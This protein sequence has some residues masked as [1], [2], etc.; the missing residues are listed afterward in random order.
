MEIDKV[1][2]KDYQRITE[3]LPKVIQPIQLIQYN[4]SAAKKGISIG[5]LK[6][7]TEEP[8]DTRSYFV[9]LP[10]DQVRLSSALR[11]WETTFGSVYRR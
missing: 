10:S 9:N 8:G 6:K 1:K 4:R 3:G 7:H 11:F 2:P 5:I